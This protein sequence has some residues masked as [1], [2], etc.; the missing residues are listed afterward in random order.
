MIKRLLT[1]VALTAAIGA[2]AY[3][4]SLTKS[5]E[6]AAPPATVWHTVGQFCDIANWHPAIATCTPSTQGG[7]KVRTL[8]LKGGGTI[9]EQ[10]VSRSNKHMKY[11]YV[12]LSSPLPV[13]NYKST[14]AVTPDGTGSKIT[15]S[16]T[17]DAKG[18]PDAKAEDVIGGIYDAGLKGISDKA[19]AQ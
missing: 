8:A 2:P 15:W 1:A 4:L 18:A 3:A 9:V 6:V 14:I 7:K 19:T 11:T 12:I 5:A 13:T 16:G 10:Q 17:F